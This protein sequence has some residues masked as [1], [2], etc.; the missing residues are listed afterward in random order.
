MCVLINSINNY[1]RAWLPT[2]V[3]LS[4]ESHGQRS[5]AGYSPLGRKESETTE[6]TELA[7]YTLL[8]SGASQVALVVKN[9]PAY[10]GDIRDVCSIPGLRRSPGGGN[11][12]PLQYFSLKNP[13]DK[14]AWR[15]TVPRGAKSRTQLRPLST[16]PLLFA[17]YLCHIC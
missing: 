11:G 4:G 12:N 16:H 3:F 9:L 5:L 7:A 14:G 1:F 17:S 13:M 10:A 6:V 2:P 15:A 8:L